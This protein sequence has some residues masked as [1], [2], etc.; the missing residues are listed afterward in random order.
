MI[1]VEHLT[2]CY[3]DLKAVDDLSFR[4]EDGQVYG[5]LAVSYTHLPGDPLASPAVPYY[6]RELRDWGMDTLILGCTHYP[7]LA[8]LIRE[9][10]YKRQ[11]HGLGRRG[12]DGQHQIALVR[13]QLIGDEIGRASWRERV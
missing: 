5:F 8:P 3:G 11:G 6:L 2:K 12:G 10:V 13:H 7:L 1:E 4:I 9:D